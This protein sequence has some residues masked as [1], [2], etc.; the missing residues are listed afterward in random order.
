MPFPP[1]KAPARHDVPLF[2]RLGEVPIGRTRNLS[3][4][5]VFLET[6]ARP[7]IGSRDDLTIA[8][9]DQVVSCVVRVVRHATDGIGLVF[10]DP[11]SA[12]SQAVQEILS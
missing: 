6:E 2:T 12:F 1:P 7:P 11:D 10:V 8:W 5:G 4:T 9:G 3:V